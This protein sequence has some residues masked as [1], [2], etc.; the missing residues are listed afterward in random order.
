MTGCAAIVRLIAHQRFGR[1]SD[2]DNIGH[3]YGRH[4]C[5]C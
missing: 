2:N 5:A 1:E 4:Q 3:D